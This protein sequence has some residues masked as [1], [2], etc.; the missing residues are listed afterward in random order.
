[1]SHVRAQIRQQIV[2]ELTA[3]V[4]LAT[5]GIFDTQVRPTDVNDL[6][7]VFV[8]LGSEQISGRTLSVGGPTLRRELQVNV[9]VRA[10]SNTNLQDMLADL[11]V[12]VETTLG[13]SVLNGLVKS[14]VLDSTEHAYSDEDQLLQGVASMTWTELYVTSESDPTQAL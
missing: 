6:P 11:S 8:Y 9:D 14:M 2:A 10:A 4:S 7:G 3:N 5:G 1:M 12:Q 13:P